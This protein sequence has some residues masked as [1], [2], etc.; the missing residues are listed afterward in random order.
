MNLK[1]GLIML[2]I[3]VAV[4][5]LVFVVLSYSLKKPVA[6]CKNFIGEKYNSCML[7]NQVCTSDSCLLDQAK[8]TG[9]ES[10]CYL[11]TNEKTKLSCTSAIEINSYYQQ[12]VLNG[13]ISLCDSNPELAISCQ[14]NYYYVEAKNSGD[15]VYC[16]SI[17]SEVIKNACLKN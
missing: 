17:D 6:E 12:A 10:K 15:S 4:S 5:V 1:K 13:N 8:M 2:G 3:A 9:N 11:I 16:S 14:D 7:K